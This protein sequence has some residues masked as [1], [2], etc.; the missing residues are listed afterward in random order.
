VCERATLR[1][2]QCSDP[3]L[4]EAKENWVNDVKSVLTEI[5]RVHLDFMFT[6]RRGDLLFDVRQWYMYERMGRD[7]GEKDELT[8]EQGAPPVSKRSLLDD[9]RPTRGLRKRPQR[10]QPSS[11]DDD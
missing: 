4:E 9:V 11:S 10:R 7:F 8:L 6:Q 1:F 2:R 3:A 5:R